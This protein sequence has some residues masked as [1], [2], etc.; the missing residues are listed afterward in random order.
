MAVR[1][2][3]FETTVAVVMGLVVVLGVFLIG[4]LHAATM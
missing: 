3:Q 4:L 2:V 1:R